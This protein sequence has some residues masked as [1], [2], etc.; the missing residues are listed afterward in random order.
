MLKLSN[1][2]R[3]ILGGSLLTKLIKVT[4]TGGPGRI[5]FIQF[6]S[7]LAVRQTLWPNG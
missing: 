5:A 3:N 7:S 1:K 4:V 2:F 6:L